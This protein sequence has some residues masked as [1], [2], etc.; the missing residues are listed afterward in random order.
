MTSLKDKVWKMPMSTLIFGLCG[1][2][3]ATAWIGTGQLTIG[4]SVLL[5]LLAFLLTLITVTNGWE[6]MNMGLGYSLPE[7][8]R[9]PP[10][11]MT[12]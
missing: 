4:L 7:D 3:G 8:V 11:K 9:D 5:G 2:S 10:H 6:R 1:A 12:R